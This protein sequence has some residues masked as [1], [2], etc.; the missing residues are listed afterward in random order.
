MCANILN[1]PLLF[2]VETSYG[3]FLSIGPVR[4]LSIHDFSP[5]GFTLKQNVIV[6]FDNGVSKYEDVI[7]LLIGFLRHE[8]YI[9][10][11]AIKPLTLIMNRFGLKAY[12]FVRCRRHFFL[13]KLSGS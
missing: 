1:V 7:V 4:H 11:L 13:V 8:R 9:L 5:V 12:Y 3:A 10:L 6:L 2:Y